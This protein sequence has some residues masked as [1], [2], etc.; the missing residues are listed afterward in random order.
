[1]M[2][3]KDWITGAGKAD[4][5]QKA[6]ACLQVSEFHVF[7]LAWTRWFGDDREPQDM[8][9]L[10]WSY[11]TEGVVPH[12]VRHFCRN[13]LEQMA[14]GRL[15]PRDFGVPRRRSTPEMLYEGIVGLILLSVVMVL[16]LADAQKS[17]EA[18]GFGSCFF[19]P[20][21]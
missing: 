9:S 7:E 19:P 8:E 21:Y 20:C 12:W 10:Y 4:E 13:V 5:V 11:V 3:D 2:P 1:M 6:A 15:D 16:L 17:G 18:M 14:S